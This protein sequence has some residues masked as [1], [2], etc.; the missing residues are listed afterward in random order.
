[1]KQEQST[2]FHLSIRW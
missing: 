1:M 2:T